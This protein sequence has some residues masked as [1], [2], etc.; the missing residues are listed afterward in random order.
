MRRAR[1]R[2]LR[3]SI[4]GVLLYND[5]NF[6]QYLEGPAEEIDRFYAIIR[7]DPLHHGII[8]LLRAPIEAREFGAWSMAFR[9]DE[10]SALSFPTEHEAL[11]LAR[12]APPPSPAAAARMLLSTFFFSERGRLLR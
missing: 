3:E 4:T 10:A 7:A 1:E 12:L 9:A 2:N 6:M 8:E 11:L 5:S